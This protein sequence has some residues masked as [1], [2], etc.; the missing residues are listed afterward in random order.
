MFYAIYGEDV[1]SSLE[2][3][4]SVRPA[5]LARLTQLQNAGRLLLAGPGTRLRD[6]AGDRLISIRPHAKEDRVTELFDKYNLLAM[7]VLDDD[8]TLVGV[9][10]ADDV[11]SVLRQK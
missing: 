11:I 8:G 9:I 1:P 6:L 2:Q 10:T 5:H 4:L 7:P 3:R